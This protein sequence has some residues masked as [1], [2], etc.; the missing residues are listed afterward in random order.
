MGKIVLSD[1]KLVARQ[2]F[3]I[4]EVLGLEGRNLG[5]PRNFGGMSWT[6]EREVNFW[7]GP[8]TSGEVLGNS[9]KSG[10][11]PGNRWIALKSHSKRSSA[12]K[13]FKNPCP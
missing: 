2:F 13:S 8:A 7:E 6:H 4:L 10:K 12:W 3:G 9:G 1:K 5:C 11:L